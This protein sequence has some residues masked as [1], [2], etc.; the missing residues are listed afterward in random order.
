LKY[1][2]GRLIEEADGKR[3]VAD[4]GGQPEIIVQTQVLVQNSAVE[5]IQKSPIHSMDTL[6]DLTQRWSI[7]GKYAYRLGQLSQE[8]INPQ[9]FD[10]QGY[11]IIWLGSYSGYG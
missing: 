4:C 3:T 5:F 10:S 11:F 1:K 9:F 2:S 6:L 7:G 8:R